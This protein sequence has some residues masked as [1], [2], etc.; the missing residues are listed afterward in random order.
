MHSLWRV[1]RICGAF[2]DWD[3]VHAVL[4]DLLDMYTRQMSLKSVDRRQRSNSC[5]H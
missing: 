1:D 4:L 2:L 3:C 5:M